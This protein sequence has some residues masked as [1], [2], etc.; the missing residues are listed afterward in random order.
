MFS[1]LTDLYTKSVKTTDQNINH[2]TVSLNQAILRAA[3]ETI[4]R[5]AQKKYR[6]YWTEELQKLEDEVSR[7]RETVEDNPTTENIAYKV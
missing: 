7:T 6:P 5:G 2:A 1:R 4:P 3:S